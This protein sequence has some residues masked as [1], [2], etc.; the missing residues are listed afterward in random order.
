MRE[1]TDLVFVL[2]APRSGTTWLKLLLEQHACPL[3]RHMFQGQETL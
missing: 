1:G 3:L 2:G